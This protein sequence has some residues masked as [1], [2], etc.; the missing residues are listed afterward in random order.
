MQSAAHITK[1][2]VFPTI[3]QTLLMLSGTPGRADTPSTI[4]LHLFARLC[5][6]LFLFPLKQIRCFGFRIAGTLEIPLDFF[7][8]SSAT[9]TVISAGVGCILALYQGPE[10]QTW[11]VPFLPI[12]LLKTKT[13]LKVYVGKDDCQFYL[14]V[15][16]GLP[17]GAAP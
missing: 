7:G 3:E 1:R 15:L 10:L 6:A 2:V 11:D 14:E 17:A 8:E 12:C 5:R 9:S 16:G 13:C 4:N